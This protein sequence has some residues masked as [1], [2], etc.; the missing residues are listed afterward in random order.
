MNQRAFNY[1]APLPTTFTA[2]DA[3]TVFRPTTDVEPFASRRSINTRAQ[4]TPWGTSGV[5]LDP[6][7]SASEMSQR[8]G[9]DFEIGYR[10]VYFG[11]VINQEIEP[12]DPGTLVRVP[13][14][15]A[16]VNERTGSWLSQ[17]SNNYVAVQPRDI[18][19]F[20][21]GLARTHD[22][23]LEAA[24]VIDDGKVLWAYASTGQQFSVSLGDKS[25]MFLLFLTSTDGRY[26]TRVYLTSI[27][28]ACFNVIG[29]V[30]LENGLLACFRHT[31]E[32]DGKELQKTFA[33]IN[34]HS[35]ENAE[36]MNLLASHKMSNSDIREYF[37][38]FCCRRD[39]LGRIVE[40]AALDRSVEDLMDRLRNGEGSE[41]PAARDTAYGVL[42][43]VIHRYDHGTKRKSAASRF[44]SIMFGPAA[45]AKTRALKLALKMI[46]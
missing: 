19:S 38:C 10:P 35:E 28:F 3:G 43:A 32:F 40:S 17:M 14:Q 11:D 39:E 7:L 30:G 16:L 22:V 21:H 41:F 15:R 8:A 45:K 33:S 25:E 37:R 34:G 6:A 27:R 24:G 4:Q 1:L 42:Q 13:H 9:F 44:A 36:M 5:V 31:S 20:Y 18:M 46:G 29:T 12:S 23:K 2:R 26:A